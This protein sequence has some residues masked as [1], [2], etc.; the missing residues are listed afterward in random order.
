MRLDAVGPAQTFL[1]GEPQTSLG[2][3][4]I[5]FLV[6][7]HAFFQVAVAG[8]AG[9][10][11]ILEWTGLATRREQEGGKNQHQD[12]DVEHVHLVELVLDAN[13]LIGLYV[14]NL[15]VDRKTAVFDFDLAFAGRDFH[16]VDRRTD[17][18]TFAIDINFTPWC[19]RQRDQRGKRKVEIKHGGF[20]VY[21]QVVDVKADQKVRIKHKFN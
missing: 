11:E 7:Q 12:S 16:F 1:Q 3:P 20:P 6:V 14:D 18:D 10:A 19:D 9:C 15:R 21:T 5:T 4:V 17:A 2:D 8:I 13:L